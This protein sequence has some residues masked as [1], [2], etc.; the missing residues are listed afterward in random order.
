MLRHRVEP[1]RVFVSERHEL[2]HRTPQRWGLERWQRGGGL[3]RTGDDRPSRGRLRGG[4]GEVRAGAA[5]KPHAPDF[6]A[7]NRLASNSLTGGGGVRRDRR[8]IDRGQTVANIM[9]RVG[10]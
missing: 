8:A 2:G 9:R 1:Q 7:A 4:A 6:T 5:A 3:A 10:G